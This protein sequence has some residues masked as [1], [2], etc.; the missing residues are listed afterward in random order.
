MC[1]KRV[2]RVCFLGSLAVYVLWKE[3]F[4]VRGVCCIFCVWVDCEDCVC[5]L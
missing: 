5:V 4:C 1:L 2:V 3:G